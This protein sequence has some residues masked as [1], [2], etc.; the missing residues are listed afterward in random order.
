VTDGG[1]SEGDIRVGDVC[2]DLSQGRPVQ[3]VEALTQNAAEWSNNNGYDLLSN[4]ANDRLES[5]PG[6]A[7]FECVYV[8]SI[9]SEPSKTYAF[10]ES[11]LVRIE[12]EA[13]DEG[14]RVDERIAVD[15][16]ESLFDAALRSGSDETKSVLRNLAQDAFGRDMT[17]EAR[18][19]A[20]VTRRMEQEAEDWVES[21][22]DEIAEA[23]F[24][25]HKEDHR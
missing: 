18:E 10:P 9:Q 1:V 19:L 15:V 21:Q 2:L 12:V 3:V 7:V 25:A 6:D 4:Y 8:G 22:E 16:L 23:A 11:R 20:E 24:E 5:E 14:R 17:S 13:G